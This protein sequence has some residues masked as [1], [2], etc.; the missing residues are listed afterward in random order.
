MTLHLVRMGALVVLLV[1]CTFYPFLP[2]EYDAL[3]VPLSAM[4]QAFGMVGLLL[5]PVGLLWLAYELRKR[6][7]RK[8]NVQINAR[9]YYFVLASIIASSIVALAV[10]FGAFMGISLSLAFLTL[11]LWLYFLS[12]VIPRLK[13]LK[14]AEPE[15]FNPA[16]F[17]L[18]F[19]PTLVLIFQIALAAPATEFSRNRAIAQSAELIGDI[20]EYRAAHGRYPSFLQA[21]NKDYYPSVVGIEQFHYTPHR[22]AYNLFFEQPTFLFDFGIREIVI[23]NKLDEHLIVSH[24]A[25]I[26]SGPAEQLEARQGWYTVHNAS[27]PHWKYFWFD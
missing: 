3:A 21:I 7:R 2:G 15:D 22:D 8:R 1:L 26:L 4:A 27:S 20:E 17:Y 10:S 19:V 12:R 9:R 18:V 5:V 14:T 11:A 24:A 23:Y 16:P 25:W 13:L 6:A